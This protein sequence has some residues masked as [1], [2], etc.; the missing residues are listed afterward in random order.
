MVGG[1]LHVFLLLNCL[2]VGPQDFTPSANLESSNEMELQIRLARIEAWGQPPYS[3]ENGTLAPAFWEG[4]GWLLIHRFGFVIDSGSMLQGSLFWRFQ[5]SR[6]SGTW[7]LC[8]RW[9]SSSNLFIHFPLPLNYGKKNICQLLPFMT[10]WS[11]TWR[12]LNPWKG[13]IKDPKRSLGS[14]RWIF[15]YYWAQFWRGG[16]LF[17][18]KNGLPNCCAKPLTSIAFTKLV[19]EIDEGG[20]GYLRSHEISTESSPGSKRSRGFLTSFW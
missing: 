18:K 17:W 1:F 12:S 14:T 2:A 11:P 15:V 20:S 10:F 3:I 16:F 9:N 8:L 4:G 13:H 5:Q 6:T 19:V 7:Y